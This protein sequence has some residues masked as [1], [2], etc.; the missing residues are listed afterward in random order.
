MCL[1]KHTCEGP[2]E[3]IAMLSW[4]T[5]GVSIKRRKRKLICRV[6]FRGF[7][8]LAL[9]IATTITSS[10]NLWSAILFAAKLV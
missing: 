3:E 7:D 5:N 10:L 8:L 1:W 4:P 6:I 9:I 2:L